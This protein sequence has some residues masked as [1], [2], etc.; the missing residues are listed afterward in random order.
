M[1]PINERHGP[2]G[3]C[4]QPGQGR[5]VFAISLTLP[6]TKENRTAVT[7]PCHGLHSFGKL[8]FYNR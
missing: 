5:Q 4:V 8:T 2:R 1:L 3:T 7:G 6:V